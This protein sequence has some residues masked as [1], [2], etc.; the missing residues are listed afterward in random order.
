MYYNNCLCDN[1]VEAGYQRPEAAVK[2]LRSLMGEWEKGRD[3]KRMALVLI[4]KM[5][6]IDGIVWAKH[7][8][9]W[10]VKWMEQLKAIANIARTTQSECVRNGVSAK[11]FWFRVQ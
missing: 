2:L 3:N 11:P 8:P 9:T 4:L 5:D 6:I 7:Y 10:E 1:F